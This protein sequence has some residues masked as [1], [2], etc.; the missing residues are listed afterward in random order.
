M[1]IEK[2]IRGRRMVASLTR[3]L[4]RSSDLRGV[5]LSLT[6]SARRGIASTDFK[7]LT[8]PSPARFPRVVPAW[9]TSSV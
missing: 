6:H 1:C 5:Y 2:G 9:P 7:L 3:V 4:P 8:L